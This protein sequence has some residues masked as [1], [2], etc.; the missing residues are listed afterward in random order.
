MESTP[1]VLAGFQARAG[2]E[3]ALALGAAA[4]R[5]DSLE[6]QR[7]LVD[8]LGASGVRAIGGTADRGAF[9]VVPVDGPGGAA[10]AA[11]DALAAAG[12]IADARGP[13]LRLCPD[14]LTPLDQIA[15]AARAVA[16]AL[17]PPR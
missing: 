8:A 15:T 4:L 6:R 12:V 2:Q 9:V 14:L 10:S 3:L 13:L 16:A 7:A 11:V 17:A 1:P 5:A